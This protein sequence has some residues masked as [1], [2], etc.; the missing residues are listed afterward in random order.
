VSVIDTATN[1]VLPITIRVGDAPLVFGQFIGPKAPG[2]TAVRSGPPAGDFCSGP[3]DGTINGDLTVSAG[4]NCG[5]INGGRVTGNVTVSGGK[6]VLSGAA[7]GGSITVGGG[8]FTIGPAATVGGDVLVSNLSAGSTDDS[9]C[10]TTIQGSLQVDGNA[11]AVQIGSSAPLV[12]AGN[13]IG[14]DLV[15]DGNSAKTLLFENQIKGALRAG[16]NSGPLDVVGNTV[17]T[18][19]HCQNNTMLIMGGNN[20]AR[21]KIGQ[22]N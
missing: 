20:T 4:Q 5:I 15:V 19:L 18:T 2:L 16:N 9:V 22:C 1:G 10:G 21:Q 7:V 6:F 17:G 3:F 14:G 13:K 12:C 8:G 11:A